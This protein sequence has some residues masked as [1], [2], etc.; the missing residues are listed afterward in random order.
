MLWTENYC[1]IISIKQ[2]LEVFRNIWAMSEMTLHYKIIPSKPHVKTKE[3]I[4]KYKYSS[5]RTIH[6]IKGIAPLSFQSHSRVSTPR[7]S[8]WE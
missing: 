8:E 4:E 7:Q 1:K 3:K 5:L 6:Q 2:T